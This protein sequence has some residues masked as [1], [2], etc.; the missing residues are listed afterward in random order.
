MIQGWATEYKQM[1][2]WEKLEDASGQSFEKTYP[3][4]VQVS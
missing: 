4:S 2:L 3:N 1:T